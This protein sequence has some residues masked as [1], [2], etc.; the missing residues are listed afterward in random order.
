MWREVLGEYKVKIVF[1]HAL[2]NTVTSQT[3]SHSVVSAAV[4]NSQ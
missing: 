3:R 1:E 4:L 2:Y